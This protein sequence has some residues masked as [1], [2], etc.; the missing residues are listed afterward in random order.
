ML[1]QAPEYRRAR[2][3]PVAGNAPVSRFALSGAPNRQRAPS[4]GVW[5]SQNVLLESSNGREPAVW[6]HKTCNESFR[7]SLNPAELESDPRT[8]CGPLT[9]SS[10][11]SQRPPSANDTSSVDHPSQ[12]YTASAATL[13]PLDTPAATVS[14][15]AGLCLLCGRVT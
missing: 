7:Q 8:S 2:D 4:R 10:R 13:V 3:V 9:P 15:R 6:V 11:T 14:A 12:P 5:A 1:E